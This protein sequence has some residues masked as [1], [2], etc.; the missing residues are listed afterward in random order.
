MFHLYR[1]YGL[2]EVIYENLRP[3]KPAK[4]FVRGAGSRARA[5]SVDEDDGDDV[6][7]AGN[8]MPKRRARARVLT[9]T[10]EGSLLAED[11]LVVLNQLEG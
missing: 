10:N 11:E 9:G 4:P 6:A 3:E 5:N 7:E 2:E 8:A 1:L